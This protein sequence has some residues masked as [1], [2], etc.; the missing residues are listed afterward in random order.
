MGWLEFSDV[1]NYVVENHYMNMDGIKMVW[2]RNVKVLMM[3]LRE[4]DEN[5]T[6]FL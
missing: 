4:Y 6:K 2:L 5:R 1:I 3:I